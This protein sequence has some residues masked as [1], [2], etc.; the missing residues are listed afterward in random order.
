MTVWAGQEHSLDKGFVAYV[1][2]SRVFNIWVDASLKDVLGVCEIEQN[3]ASAPNLVFV[4]SCVRLVQEARKVYIE[5][6]R[7]SAA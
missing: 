4:G 2:L 5:E 7:R 6:P 3:K 1:T